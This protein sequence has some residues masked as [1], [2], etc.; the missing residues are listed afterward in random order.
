MILFLLI[1]TVL[2]NDL[3]LSFKEHYYKNGVEVIPTTNMG[4]TDISFEIIGKN[5]NQK[6]RILNLSIIESYP[7]AFKNALPN[8]NIDMLRIKQT[9]TLFISKLININE[10]N[11]TN[12]SLWIRVNGIHEGTGENVYSEGNY[13]LIL[14]EKI[15]KEPGILFSIGNK[16]WEDNP[17]GGIL[18]GFVAI[19]GVG[20][21]YWKYKFSDKL[22]KY[23]IKSERKRNKR[24]FGEEGW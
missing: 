22:E 21:I 1:P 11:Q 14:N 10:F 4:F 3:E 17:S 7:I 8:I 16:I 13:N 15:E 9:K 6:Y 2:A 24:K 20:F 18:V 5:L 12:I 19:F 23:R